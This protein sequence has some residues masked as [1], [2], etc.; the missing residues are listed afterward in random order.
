M[1]TPNQARCKERRAQPRDGSRVENDAASHHFRFQPPPKHPAIIAKA[2][3]M[4]RLIRNLARKGRAHPALPAKL[5]PV[6]DFG[7][8][9]GNLI[10][11][12]FVP[13]GL[14]PGAALVTV[15]HGCSQDADGYDAG[16]QWSVLAQRHGF[17][18]LYPEQ[19]RTNNPMN[20]F[21]WYE[22]AATARAGGETASILAMVAHMLAAHGLDGRRVFITGLSAGGAM[23]AALLAAAPD[24]FAGGA[25]IAGLPHGAAGSVQEALSV[26]RAPPTLSAAEWGG[27]VREAHAHDGPRPSVSLWHGSADTTVAPANAEASLAQWTDV[28]DLDA[29]IFTT[30]RF[31]P[32]ARRVWRDEAGAARV[33][34]WHIEGMGHGTPV[35]PS[36]PAPEQRLGQT[37]PYMLD[38]GLASTWHI[39][40]D[41]GLLE[42]VAKVELAAPPVAAEPK[43]GR[44]AKAKPG[45]DAETPPE[46]GIAGIINAA[47]RRAGLM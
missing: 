22:P 27:K 14:A 16:S 41:W 32:H 42:G 43:A 28:L 7:A 19:R 12:C 24:V 47:L 10:M 9:P 4:T 1:L 29:A 25:I 6:A 2:P 8:N 44:G 45:S 23:A 35:G 33:Q 5:T 31:G 26:M 30:E 17:A 38:A 46:T 40:K 13:H 36:V 39:A 11:K 3:I 34:L 21:K 15:L 20:C 37:G 18:L